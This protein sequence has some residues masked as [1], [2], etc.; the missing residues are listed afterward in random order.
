MLLKNRDSEVVGT[1][2]QWNL[3]EDD[4]YALVELENGTFT[5]WPLNKIQKVNY[6]TTPHI[7]EMKMAQK[8]LTEFAAANKNS[9]QVY[10]FRAYLSKQIMWE[11][12]ELTMS[13]DK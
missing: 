1:F 10:D 4:S 3:T 9:F 6:I 13:K 8:I 7:E 11:T 2:I 5:E 12:M